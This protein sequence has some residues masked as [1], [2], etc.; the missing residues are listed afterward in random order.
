MQ[1]DYN[2]LNDKT[3]EKIYYKCTTTLMKACRL[4]WSKYLITNKLKCFSRKCA[5]NIWPQDGLDS[6]DVAKS[7][8]VSTTYSTIFWL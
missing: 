3:A 1:K 4:Q 7:G 5:K 6:A 8:G 2:S